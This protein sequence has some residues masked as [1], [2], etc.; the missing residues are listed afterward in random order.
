MIPVGEPSLAGLMSTVTISPALREVFDQPARLRMLGARPSQAHSTLPPFPSSATMCSQVWGLTH[1]NS[2][3]TP[4][5]VM[6]F[7]T[8]YATLLWWDHAG[9]AK[10][11]A[12]INTLEVTTARLMG[13]ASSQDFDSQ[14]PRLCRLV[15]LA[16]EM[17]IEIQQPMAVVFFADGSFFQR[18]I[19]RFDQVREVGPWLPENLRVLDG[20]LKGQILADSP[21]ALD[22][23]HRIRVKV[24][25]LTKPGVLYEIGRVDDQCV[26]LPMADRIAIVGRIGTC[27]MFASIGRDDTESVS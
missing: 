14:R 22:D 15:R 12:A 25:L 24:T 1:S 23:V 18:F 16:L 13:P 8:S 9:T 11:K 6:T 26:A 10:S 5:T 27:A 20:N 19:R 2:L 3:T 4:E 7:V 17:M 21:E